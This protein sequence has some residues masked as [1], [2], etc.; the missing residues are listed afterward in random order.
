[1]SKTDLQ[2]LQKNPASGQSFAAVLQ[3]MRPQIAMALPRHMNPDRVTRL[4]L[5]EFRKNSALGEC[6]PETVL[7]AIVMLSQLGLEIGVLG[8]AY[9]VPYYNSKARRKECQGI[10]GW[11]GIV[12]LINR[13][14]RGTIWSG[15][16]YDGDYFDYELGSDPFV[17]HK[18]GDAH[19]LGEILY[20]YAV[21][22]AKG[23]EIPIIEVWSSARLKTHRDRNNKVGDS[24]YSYKNWEM[25][26]RKVPLL[27][28]SKYMPKSVELQTA[29]D[30]E[31]ASE[32]GTTFDLEAMNAMQ[33]DGDGAPPPAQ[34]QP[35][36]EQ[37]PKPKAAAAA[38]PAEEKSQEP[39]KGDV[40]APAAK[41]SAGISVDEIMSAIVAAAKVADLDTV[42]DLIRS[43]ESAH[44]KSMLDQMSKNKR[45]RLSKDVGLNME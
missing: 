20:T 11:Q 5:T 29:L 19:G 40:P 43:V 34:E 6:A 18:P 38:K 2:T 9:L 36:Q 31:G 13:S 41:A 33:P 21:G 39:T 37:K 3:T 42:D 28:V 24:H 32:T 12:E 30:L 7:G 17:K 14:G 15:A 44:E 35:Q 45:S 16:V 10:P 23:A 4:A 26:A 8:Q 22:K 1:M 27:Q 25:Y